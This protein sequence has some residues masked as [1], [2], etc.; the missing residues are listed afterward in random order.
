MEEQIKDAPDKTA[1]SITV[2][3]SQ[4]PEIT[5]P[6]ISVIL[7]L[8][9]VLFAFLG[10]FLNSITNY[11]FAELFLISLFAP[12]IGV[13]TGIISL[14]QGIRRIGVIGV[15]LAVIA[16]AAPFIF[17]FSVIIGFKTGAIVISM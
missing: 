5:L 2:N 6:V 4:K 10:S 9:P 1:E 12:I 17:V 14:C 16:I 8:L 7:D 13:I 11:A 3:V 15:V